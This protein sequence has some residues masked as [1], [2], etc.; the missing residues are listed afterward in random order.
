MIKEN[1][2]TKETNTSLIIT[3]LSGIS[4]SLGFGANSGLKY[5]KTIT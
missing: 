4:S 5:A 2:G 1:N 3:D